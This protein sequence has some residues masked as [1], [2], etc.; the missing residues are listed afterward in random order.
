MELAFFLVDELDEVTFFVLS[1]VSFG[2]LLV[3]VVV[4]LVIG[5]ALDDDVVAV[6]VVIAA[7]ATDAAA[8]GVAPL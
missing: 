5:A 4:L 3:R 8:A 7:V 2:S 6:D 1:S